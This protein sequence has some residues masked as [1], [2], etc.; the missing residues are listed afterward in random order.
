MSQVVVIASTLKDLFNT[1]LVIMQL[2][3][4]HFKVVS[5]GTAIDLRYGF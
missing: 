1:W 4:S 3:Q 5:G 2:E